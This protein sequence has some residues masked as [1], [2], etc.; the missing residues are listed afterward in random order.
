MISRRELL[1]RAGAFAALSP[2][3]GAFG[4]EPEGVI[5]AAG[6]ALDVFDFELSPDEMERMA[7]LDRHGAGAV[8]SDRF[9][10]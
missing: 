1:R 5:T 8:D 4:G 2:A 7:S 6:K 9:G 3:I 10:H